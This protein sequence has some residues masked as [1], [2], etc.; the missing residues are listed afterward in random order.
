MVEISKKDWALFRSKLPEWQESYMGKLVQEYI[1]LLSE[2]RY[3]SDKF[4]DLDEKLK[5]DKKH[6]GVQLEVRKSTVLYDIAR[7][8]KDG[9]ITEGDLAEFS[10]DTVDAVHLILGR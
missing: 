1:D 10:M 5:K 3:A 6:P 8:L 2:D 9:V 4:W 7:F